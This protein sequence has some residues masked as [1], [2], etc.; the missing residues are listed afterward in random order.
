MKKNLQ[1]FSLLCL[2]SLAIIGCNQQQYYF[3]KSW[4]SVAERVWLGSEFWANRLQ[5]WKV[6]N[7]RLEC[8]ANSPKLKMR[9]AHLINV[10]LAKA[11][12]DF[13]ADVALGPIQA[14]QNPDAAAGFLIGA[15]PKLDVWGASLIQQK[16]GPGAGL[17][18]GMAANGDLFVK[19]MEDGEILKTV[20]AKI[21]ESNTLHIK[22]TV[23][24][25]SYTLLVQCGGVELTLANISA[26][27]LIG[28]IALVSHPGTGEQPGSFW[29]NNLKVA[30]DKLMN[31]SETSG[32]VISSQYTLSN[33]TLKITAQL[34]PIA[35]TDPQEVLFEI[36]KEGSWQE[37]AQAKIITPG[38]TATFKIN[39]WESTLDTP[40][41]IKYSYQSST[42]T[43]QEAFWQGTIKH[44][45]IEKEEIVIAGFT[46]N[47]NVSHPGLS[48]IKGSFNF[49]SS[50]IWY[51]H[52][53]IVENMQVHQPDVLFFSGDQLYE[54]SSPTFPDKAHYELDYLYKWYLYCLAYRHLTKDIPTISIPD[55]HDIYQGNLWGENG[56]A[57]D[58]DNKGG[59]VHPAWFVQMVERTQ[60]SNLPDPYDPTPVEQNIGVYYTSITYGGIGFA[61]L[62]DRK[63]KSGCADNPFI[64]KGR[65]D[66]VVDPEFDIRKIDLPGKKL[67]GDRQLKFLDDWST[68][69]QGQDMKIAL[70][71][72]IF[73]NMA[74]HHGS[75]LFRLIADLDANGWPQTGRNKAVDALRKSFTFH[76]AGDQHLASIVHHGI[77][78][79][80][81]AI[82]SFCVPSI[83]NFYPRAWWPES[84]GK[85]RQ[86]GAPQNMGQ[87]KDGFGKFVIVFAVTNPTGLTN[88]STNQEPL[89][90]HDKMPGYGIVRLNK[91]QRTIKMECWPRYADPL[92]E[93]Q[94]YKG[95]P[96]TIS[97]FDNYGRQAYAYLPKISVTGL[98][99]PVLEIRNEKTGELVYCVRIKGHEI[100]AKVFSE[101]SYTVTL[102]DTE[103]GI[104][105]VLKGILPDVNAEEIIIAF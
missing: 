6:Q 20:S 54:G 35:I 92:K 65:P 14:A 103:N 63:F 88:I 80:D 59:Y 34:A 71:Q 4:S 70:S 39:D 87:H 99:N 41:R 26:E 24:N 47:H 61:V 7:G 2:F 91:Q 18:V 38:Y 12:A 96:K 100:K 83:A 82:Y 37:I 67:L 50:G 22:A 73:A 32:P 23:N 49:D 46:G 90:L 1:Q 74:T 57:T 3:E 98:E 104:D 60:C 16:P 94:Q 53:S 78:Q 51:P 97:Q 86:A 11:M 105:K 15:G 44:D 30:G 21:T 25:A 64:T 68:N 55:D 10:R 52:K 56:K 9:T 42:K 5:D 81:D 43:R 77:D 28:N 101:S 66:H 45:P 95:W 69:W 89:G 62:E 19:N 93:E 8:I 13:Q 102:K 79:W 33:N 75:E 72:T 85:N 17:F 31:T 29:F 48:G 36:N 40:Y 58:R 76:L 84:I 27:K